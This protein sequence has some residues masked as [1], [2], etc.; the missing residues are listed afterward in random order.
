MFLNVFNFFFRKDYETN[1]LTSGLLQLAPHT[2]L[3]LDETR[4]APGKLEQNGT[5]AIATFARLILEEKLQAN[6]Q[7]YNIDYN[8]NVAVLCLSEGK[9]MLPHHYQVPLQV[10]P[11]NV[12]LIQE[13]IEA[14]K[15]FLQPKLPA[16]RALLTKLRLVDF[17]MRSANM[18]S[19]QDEFVEMRKRDKKVGADELH[20][21]MVLARYLGTFH[22]RTSL[23]DEIWELAKRLDEERIARLAVPKK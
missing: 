22:G 1:K 14:A 21:R 6:F 15:H 9:S 5:E 12:Q 16:I 8:M 20:A 19:V 11:A 10:D 7:Y 17:D 13:T 23:D 2:T 3:V 18:Q 4:L